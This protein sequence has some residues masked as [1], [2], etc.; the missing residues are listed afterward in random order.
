[1][2]GAAQKISK[3][4]QSIEN[5]QRREAERRERLLGDPKKRM[6]GVDKDTLDKQVQ[7]RKERENLDKQRD[8]FF[9]TQRL[10]HANL[11]D[12]LERKRQELRSENYKQIQEFRQL[13]QNKNQTREWDLNDPD[14]WKFEDIGRVHDFHG[15]DLGRSERLKAQKE[16]QLRWIEQ[17]QK[18]LEDRRNKEKMEEAQYEYER[19][20]LAFLSQ[21]LE[22]QRQQLR[23]QKEQELREYNLE[24]ARSRQQ[25]EFE[26]LQQDEIDRVQELHNQINSDFLNENFEATK[27]VVDPNKFRPYNFKGLRPDQKEDIHQTVIKQIE[28]KERLQQLEKL[29]EKAWEQQMLY[30]AH[31]SSKLQREQDRLRTQIQKDIAET[32]RQFAEMQKEKTKVLDEVY[33]GKVTDAFFSQFGTSSR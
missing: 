11:A 23:A 10:Q 21:Q 28:E 25:K 33:S 9:D 26:Q 15:E 12:Q 30:N 13:F 22:D 14:S 27:S 18:D 2:F 1:M 17:Q 5:R 3:E 7:E 8:L 20:Q 16:Q 31:L 4:Q 6:F 32:N 24:L 29:E 19:L